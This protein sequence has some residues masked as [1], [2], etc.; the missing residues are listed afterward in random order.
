MKVK[1]GEIADIR[2]GVHST[3]SEQGDLAY[4]QAKH[5]SEA[6]ELLEKPDEFIALD[7]GT[8]KHVLK[9][10]AVLLIGKGDRNTAY[11]YDGSFGPACAA[12]VFFTLEVTQPNLSPKYLAVF[13]NQPKTQQ[14]IKKLGAGNSINSIRK[15]E[16]SNLEIPIP[17]QKLQK[18]IIDLNRLQLRHR[19]LT[20]EINQATSDLIGGSLNQLIYHG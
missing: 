13:L 11:A 6:G 7:K 1:L 2:F 12:S 4:L 15:S 18:K 3:P 17:T 20:K 5:I 14:Q 9:E 10:G 16:L 19:R 8:D